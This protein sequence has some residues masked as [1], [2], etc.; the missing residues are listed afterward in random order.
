MVAAFRCAQCSAPVQDDRW[1]S[2]PYCGTV[3][4]KPTI[5]PLRAV[6]APERFAAAERSPAHAALMR[7]EPSG[8]PLLVGMG[9]KGVFLLVWTALTGAMTIFFLP[10]GP[11]ALA[12]ALM[13][14]FGVVMLV[15]TSSRAASFASAPLE[16]RT[17]VWRD[18]RIQVSGGSG[19]RGATTT[20]FVLLEGRDGERVELRCDGSIAGRHAPG[21]IGV[22][23]LRGGMLLDFQRLEV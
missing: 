13:G 1:T 10:H 11:M 7:R 19:D 16:R 9:F 18:E 4:D 2:C 21:D 22:A 8:T 20:H 14:V 17:A 5:D 6:V 23:Y 3:L 15:K 12:P